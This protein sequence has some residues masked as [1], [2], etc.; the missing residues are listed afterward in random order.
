MVEHSADPQVESH[1][2]RIFFL[3]KSSAAIYAEPGFIMVEH[4]LVA[5]NESVQVASQANAL[6]PLKGRV[7]LIYNACLLNA[8]CC[9]FNA[10]FFYDTYFLL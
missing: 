10:V 8:V 4:R 2:L 5:E 9:L 7:A 1:K 3:F 6:P